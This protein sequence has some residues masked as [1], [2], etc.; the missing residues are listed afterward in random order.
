MIDQTTLA[1]IEAL[2]VYCEGIDEDRPSQESAQALLESIRELEQKL[3]P[4][5]E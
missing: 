1:L 4:I 2:D 3:A 5:A